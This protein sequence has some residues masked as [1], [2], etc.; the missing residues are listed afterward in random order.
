MWIIAVSLIW[1][2][3]SAHLAILLSSFIS[4]ETSIDMRMV[5]ARVLEFPAVTICN[6]NPIKKSV[7]EA[8]AANNPLLQQL[9]DLDGST[10][11]KQNM[12]RK[13]GK[14]LQCAIIIASFV[15]C[16]D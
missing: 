8:S 4:N 16:C 12:R 14:L 13:R 7:L 10:S 11:T 9:M 5:D 15:I 2:F 1:I 3:V 6:A